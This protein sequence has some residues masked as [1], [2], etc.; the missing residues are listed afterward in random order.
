MALDDSS[1][2][3]GETP[4]GDQTSGTPDHTDNFQQRVNAAIATV[5]NALSYGRKLHGLGGAQD[6]AGNMPMI[7]GNQSESG[8]PPRRPQ[9]RPQPRPQQ[10]AGRMPSVPGTPSDSGI[11][12][13]QPMPGPLPPTNNPFGKRKQFAND[14]SGAIPDDDQEA[15]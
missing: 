15:A 3:D 13:I 4:G 11:P 1:L 10:V 14:D 6:M 5:D 7:P 2:D 12:P 8:L 9:P